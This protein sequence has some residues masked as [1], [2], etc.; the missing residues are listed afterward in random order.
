MG[1]SQGRRAALRWGVGA[2]L[3]LGTLVGCSGGGGKVSAHAGA[4]PAADAGPTSGPGD[5]RPPAAL[6]PKVD[7][8]PL[9]AAVAPTAGPTKGERTGSD[10]ATASGAAC[11][12]GFRTSGTKVN[13]RS[14]VYCTAWKDVAAAI[15]QYKDRL[16]S[17]PQ[18]ARGPVVREPGLGRGA[19]RY[20]NVKEAAPFRS[21]LRLLVRDSNLE[22]EVQ[23]QSLAPLTDQQVTAAWPAMA[24]TVRALLPELRS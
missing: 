18:E 13:G 24:K 1:L 2:L 10:P 3:V 15:K 14:I 17:A 9:T 12:Q 8:A 21:D 20:E 19:F 7:F 16:S 6:C 5:Y 4:T 23:V 11:L 22:C